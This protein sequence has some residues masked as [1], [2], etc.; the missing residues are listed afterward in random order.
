MKGREL[1]EVI[2]RR[3]S[4]RKYEKKPIPEEI[5]KAIL[6]AG[7]L[8]PTAK[9]LQPWHFI[10]VRDPEIKRKL[11]FTDWNNFIE[12]ASV[13]IVGCGEMDKKWAV[14]DVAIA[15]QNMVIAAEALGL[16]SCWI[17]AFEEEEVKRALGV[18]DHLKVVAMITIG[19]PAERPEPPPKK[20]L[21]E[22]VQ[23][24]KI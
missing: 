24:E 15:L 21:E 3:R 1:L 22:I 8:A 5:L 2:Y 13:V 12:E 19:Y 16:G 11:I 18:P 6:E 14:V 17:G 10:V 4:V 9:N 20:K 7:R 23:F